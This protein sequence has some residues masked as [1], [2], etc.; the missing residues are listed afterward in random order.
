MPAARTPHDRVSASGPGSFLSETT[1]I[2]SVACSHQVLAR[3]Y[4]AR[5]DVGYTVRTA[6]VHVWK[7]VVSN[8][9]R[10]LGEILPALMEQVIDALAS[11]GEPFYLTNLGTAA[12]SSCCA[13]SEQK[14][15]LA[16]ATSARAHLTRPVCWHSRVCV[17]DSAALLI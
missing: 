15:M 11:A 13:L 6:A 3:V 10:T 1:C 12:R 2:T 7:T 5:S 17:Q 14:C 16:I 9:P 8:T 4:M